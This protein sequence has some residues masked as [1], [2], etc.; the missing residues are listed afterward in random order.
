MEETNEVVLEEQFILRLP[1]EEAQKVREI[2]HTK[3][4]K[5]KKVM[6]IDL[7]LNDNQVTVNFGKNRLSGRLRK[8]PTIIESYKTNICNNKS[9]LFKTAD[10]CHIADC[11]YGDIDDETAEKAET[12]HGLCPSLKNV[13]KK[14]FRKT[15]FNKDFAVEAEK[16][17]KELYYLLSTDLEAVS[18]KFEIIYEEDPNKKQHKQFEN[19]LFGQFSSD[20]SESENSNYC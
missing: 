6:K 5:L 16:I 2:L 11:G 19:S 1:S 9:L 13:K 15:L 18:S 17:S 3:P 4:E 14:R 7:D 10:I 20:S 8:L 12:I